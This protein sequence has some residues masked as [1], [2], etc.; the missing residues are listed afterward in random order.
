MSNYIGNVAIVLGDHDTDA[1]KTHLRRNYGLE[2]DTVQHVA[3][4][5]PYRGE[6]RTEG[7]TLLHVATEITLKKELYE[8]KYIDS[9]LPLEAVELTREALRRSN[10]ILVLMKDD[11]G[12]LWYYS[13]SNSLYSEE[14]DYY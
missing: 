5:A 4:D 8:L 10:L 11:E 7:N 6:I 14:E 12:S 2:V 9:T 1:I 13:Y 3:P